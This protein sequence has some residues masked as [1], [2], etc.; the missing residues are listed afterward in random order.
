MSPLPLPLI[1]ASLEWAHP[2][3]Q[4]WFVGRFGTPTEPQEQGWPHIIE[5]HTTLISAPTGSGKTLAAFLACIDRLVRKA[6]AGDLQ[7]RT[8]VLYVSPLKALGNDIQKNLEGPLGEI[9]QM[10]GERGLLMPEIRTAVRTGDTLMHERRAMLKRPPHILVTTPESLYILLTAEKSRAILRDVETVIVDEIHAVADDKRGAHL[11][12]SLE[13]LEAL[14]NRPPA[15]IGLSATQKPIE[16]VAHFLTGSGRRDP[17]IVNVGHKRPMDIAIEVP[18]SQLGPVASNEMWDEIYERISELVRQH[19]STLVFVNTRRL[20]ERVAHNLAERL[21]DEAVAAHHGS[22]SRKLRLNAER[23]LKN[24]EI[25]VLVATASLELGID[26]GTVDLVC[27]LSSTRAIAVALQRVGRSGHWRGAI[28]KGRLFAM[29][30]DELVECAALVRAIRQGDL[31]RLM[32]PDCPL[33]ILAQQIVAACAAEEWLEHDLFALMRRAYPYRAL[34][35]ETFDSIVTMLSDGIA[36]RRG[37]Y[38]AYL[39]RDQVNGRLRARRGARLAAITSG[40]AIPETAL[41]TVVAEPEGTMVGTLDEDFAVESLAG[42]VVLLGN[43]SWRIRRVEGKTGRVIVEDAHGAPPGVP[44]WLGEAPARTAELSSHL[45]DLRQEISDRLPNISPVGFSP[46]QPVVAETIA[47]LKEE[48]GL[49]DAGAEQIVE[50]ILQGRAVLG[51]VPTQ[52]TIIA[53]RFF[54]EGGGMQLIIHA[55][56]GGRINKAWGL[57]LRKRFCRSFN[58]ELQAAATDNGLNIALA[59]Q[60]SFPLTDVFQFLQP[61]TVQP[62]LE[63]AALASPIFGTRWRWDANRSLALLRFMGGKKVPP[64]IQRMRSDDLMASVFPDVAACQE[65]IVGD[66]QIP[67]H[68]LL[69]EVM[70]DVLTEAMDLDGLKSVLSGIADERIRCLAVDTPIP[71]QFSHEILNANP[72]AYLDD[73][74]LEER[75]ARAVEMR[76]ILPES[77]LQEVGK[78]DPAAIAQVRQEAWPD[79]RDADELHDLLLT[80][81]ALPESVA[82]GIPDTASTPISEWQQ[83][84][85]QLRSNHRAGRAVDGIRAYW[86]ASERVKSFSAL[87]PNA[88]LEPSMMATESVV[89][90]SDDVLLASLQGWMA[91]VG[92]IS[93]SQLTELL[94]VPE[95]EINRALLR[96]EAAGSI[97]RGRFTDA[98]A[99]TGVVGSE[100]QTALQD[101]VE[102]CDR[103]LL[104]R[105]HRLTVGT[106]RKQIQPVTAAQFMRWLL[107]WQHVAAGTQVL[108]ERGTL[109]VLRQLQGFEVAANAWERQVLGR[110]VGGYDPAVLDRLCLTG[111]VGWGRLSPHPATLEDSAEGKRRVIPTSVAPITFFVREEA[112]WMTPRHPA[113]ELPEQTR[114]LS[115]G[116]QQTL[117]FLRHRGASFFADIVRGTGKLKSEIETALWELVAAGIV[118]ADGFDN[119]RSL[120]DPKRRAGQGSGRTSRP[121]HSSGRW[122]LLYAGEAS[123][124]NK[125]VE[126]TCWML[127]KR[128]GIVFRDLLARETILPKWRELQIA[129]RRLEDRGEI[130]GGRFVDG[131]LGEQFALPVAVES[132]RA[133]RNLQPSGETITLSAADPLNLVGIL[134]PGE[135]VPAISGKTITFR[136]GVAVAEEQALRLAGD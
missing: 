67:D 92:P 107:R 110:R 13:R 65:N 101:Q 75:R 19:R 134:V 116:A 89:P 91:H 111:A 99:R 132:L 30:R 109:D 35:R 7:D 10:A 60:H 96:M 27:Q 103:R 98:T 90:S 59:E 45:A 100:D 41:F 85:E 26:I 81:I 9:L 50:Y 23:K 25:R 122:S 62:I 47:W 136:D 53:E 82:G 123:D 80:L 102:W 24:G 49:D 115:A 15:R 5:G 78:L 33:D 52:R 88:R 97:L 66:I 128:Y 94:G 34:S 32:I 76:R 42:D 31:D 127:L 63:Q 18:A 48:C 120:I 16:L 39:H 29:T 87:F 3:V 21:G 135:R 12:L 126:A 51:A 8:E 119:L 117:D 55:P 129:F 54:D 104:A 1:P 114:W 40:G 17:V 84:F 69:R 11:S 72:Y 43:T 56:F 57:A 124:K 36:S 108:G 133:S 86:V 105:I 83:F 64:Q 22:L 44:F 125:A 14:A 61:E 73:A 130:R 121:R 58:F 106:L 79:L 131:F 113:T 93:S 2:L 118:T 74:P 20:A 37:R 70:K 68:P 77:V 4:E 28:P 71:S 6:L 46:T 112:D 95:G 38:G